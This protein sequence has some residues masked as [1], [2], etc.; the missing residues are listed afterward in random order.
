M[1]A[2][3]PRVQSVGQSPG[4]RGGGTHAAWV[5]CPSLEKVTLPGGRS[6]LAH[7]LQSCGVRG[8][9]DS[10]PQRREPAPSGQG[11]IAAHVCRNQSPPLPVSPRP[12]VTPPWEG[13][14]LQT[15]DARPAGRQAAGLR[16][17]VSVPAGRGQSP[18]PTPGPACAAPTRGLR[19][20]QTRGPRQVV[21][22]VPRQHG[23]SQ[24]RRARASG[25][26]IR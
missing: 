2:L 11:V 24:G 13:A 15:G 22:C 5:R 7:R 23:P 9:Q 20:L 16:A 21:S 8:R 4:Q 18:A 25:P 10:A 1:A 12:V 19:A 6:L 26:F 17:R 3:G 14:E